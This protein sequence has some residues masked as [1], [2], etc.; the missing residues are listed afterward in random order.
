MKQQLSSWDKGGVPHTKRPLSRGDGH[1]VSQH[2]LF[3]FIHLFGNRVLGFFLGSFPQVTVSL[4][5]A[6][7]RQWTQ[8]ELLIGN[9]LKLEIMF[10]H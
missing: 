9:Y 8:I 10:V 3:C 1:S 4:R 2:P 5:L 7:G 6:V